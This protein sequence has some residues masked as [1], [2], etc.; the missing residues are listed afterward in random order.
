[1]QIALS[2][3]YHLTSKFGFPN[4]G[5]AII[6]LT[7]SI[8]MLLLPLTIKQVKSMRMMKEL[9]PQLK[10]LQEKHKNN[11][12]KQQEE[13]SKLYKNAGVNPLAGCLP[14]L[15][16]MPFLTGIFYMI[17]NFSYVSQPNFLWIKN[18]AGSDPFYILPVL[19]MLTTYV[20]TQQTMADSSQNKLM[21]LVMPCFIGYMTMRFPA[22][23]GLYWVVSNLVQIIQQWFLYRKPVS[24]QRMPV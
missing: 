15:I 13:I 3:F 12:L 9:G 5:V 6:L 22:G 23:L 1:M 4:Y 2:F 10:K 21:L 16:Q 24:G 18:L 17:R 20:S 14:L 19:A 11:K 7:V 8:K